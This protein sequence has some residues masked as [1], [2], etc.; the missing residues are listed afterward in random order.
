MAPDSDFSNESNLAEPLS[1]VCRPA[2]TFQVFRVYFAAAPVSQV[3][4]F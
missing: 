3:G 4:L 2:L 1:N